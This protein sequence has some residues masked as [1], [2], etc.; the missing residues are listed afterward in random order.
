M[1]GDPESIPRGFANDDED[2]PELP[3]V[4]ILKR[5]TSL[6]SPL[7]NYARMRPGADNT[8]TSSQTVRSVTFEDTVSFASRRSVRRPLFATSG[9]SLR[10]NRPA[11]LR[12]PDCEDAEDVSLATSPRLA[13]LKHG[14]YTS[15][16]TSAETMW[17]EEEDVK[18][19]LDKE[20][21]VV[22]LFVTRVFVLHSLLGTF[23]EP[24]NC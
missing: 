10:L 2:E 5:S 20:Y 19:E 11:P 22:T 12:V 9:D 13:D 23:T 21:V 16:I 7:A 8:F 6:G 4:S 14:D 3:P 18:D 24:A 15:K 17:R 1:K